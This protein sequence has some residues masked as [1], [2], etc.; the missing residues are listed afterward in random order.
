M[1]IYYTPDPDEYEGE[2]RLPPL[3]TPMAVSAE[4]LAQ[5]KSV[6]AYVTSVAADS[7][8]G[9]VFYDN[10]D[11]IAQLS[12]VLAPDVV[13]LK[14]AQMFHALMIGVGD[15]IGALAPPE[16]EVNYLFPGYIMLNRGRAGLV[17][18]AMAPTDNDATEQP[19]WMV[20]SAA[21]RVNAD[22]GAVLAKGVH[23]ETSLIEESATEISATRIVEA[24]SRHFL[25]WI[26]R[27][28]EDGFRPLFDAWQNRVIADAV[29]E[30]DAGGIADWIGLDED[31]QALLKIDGKP[32]S[33][34]AHRFA[35]ITG[36]MR[37]L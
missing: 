31:G 23:D 36:P 15:A 35:D 25:A 7:E 27:W 34:P 32:V 6:H 22:I 2:P 17:E 33:V 14:A 8:V 18:V 20:A 29:V 9:T 28:E 5:Y 24:S 19:A 16:V 30:L 1:S 21:L 13:A 4:D 12:V 11:G 10:S 37:S 3:M 26:N